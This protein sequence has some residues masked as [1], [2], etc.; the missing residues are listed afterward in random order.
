MTA[1]ITDCRYCIDTHMP[2]GRCDYMGELFERCP[3]CTQ[4]C[5]SCDGIAVFPANYNTPV[6]L[7]CDLLAFR[8]GP[9]FC[10]ACLGV[11]SLIYLGPTEATP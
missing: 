5:P 4:P 9:I 3:E 8:L 10:P 1:S 7:V 11:L 2:A 6:E